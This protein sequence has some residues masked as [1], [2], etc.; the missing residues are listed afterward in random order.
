MR[1]GY[2]IW[3]TYFDERK[4]VLK[5]GNFQAGSANFYFDLHL[6][7]Q[8]PEYRKTMLEILDFYIENFFSAE[9]GIFISYDDKTGYRGDE[10]GEEAWN[11]MHKFNDNFNFIA[12]MNAYSLTGEEKYRQYIDSYLKW[13]A[14]K[15]HENGS[16]GMFSSSVSSCVCALNFMNAF[17]MTRE[18][19]FREIAA[20][21]LDHMKQSVVESD[22]PRSNGD[23]LGLD[24]CKV[25]PGNDVIC[26]RVTMYA[27][28]AFI[29]F[30]IVE[31]YIDTGRIDDIP[32]KTA[33]SPL[34]PG[35]RFIKNQAS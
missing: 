16:F 17:L 20:K 21:A 8:K 1:N 26:L 32:E 2:P 28:Y 19:R 11:D 30:D 35:L 18:K 34:F 9:E 14:T 31:K 5:Y 33:L 22:D 3:T 27:V 23:I 13:A 6:L 7:T 12:V 4:N 15:Q 29:L 10:P 25:A 24:H